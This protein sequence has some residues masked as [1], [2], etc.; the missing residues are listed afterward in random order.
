MASLLE[1]RNVTKSFGGLRAVKEVSFTLNAGEIVFIIG[2]NGAGK[3]T[4]FNLISGFLHPD[5]GFIL[6]N[7]QDI[8]RMAP[9]KTA[10]LGVGR[11]FQIVKPL[12]T[13]SVL[14]NVMLGAFMHT[15]SLDQ[16]RT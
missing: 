9:H 16:A 10:R 14:E 8:S 5:Q 12:P 3:T 1:L 11:T 4:V 6:F 13:L 7:G 2:P 15:A